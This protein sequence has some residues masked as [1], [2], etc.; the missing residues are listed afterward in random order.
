[1]ATL[2]TQAVIEQQDEEERKKKRG[3]YPVEPYTRRLALLYSRYSTSEQVK[4]SV[5]KGVEQSSTLISRATR[6]YDWTR[7]LLVI[8][9]ENKIAEDGRVKSVSGTIPIEKRAQLETIY[10][11]YIPSGKVGAIFVDDVSRL[12]R[13]ADLVDAAL[14]ARACKKHDVI[15]IT[16]GRVYNFRRE[17]DLDNFLDEAKAAALWLKTH[18]HDKM[19]RNRRIKVEEQGKLGNGVAPIGLM[20]HAVLDP[21]SSPLKRIYIEDT[22]IPS[23]HAPQVAWLHRRFRELA[24]SKA[25]LLAELAAMAQAGNPL[26]PVVDGIRPGTIYL[27]R[28]ERDGALLGWTIASRYG[29]ENILGNLA[30]KG[31]LVW[32]GRIVKENAWDAIV[33]P[34]DWQYAFDHVAPVDENNQ[35]VKRQAVKRFSQRD[36]TP[37]TALLAGCRHDGKPVIDGVGD[38]NVFVNVGKGMYIVEKRVGKY[39]ASAYETGISVSELD[40]IVERSILD[41]LERTQWFVDRIEEMPVRPHHTRTVKAPLLDAVQTVSQ[42]KVVQPSSVLAGIDGEIKQLDSDLNLFGKIMAVE[43]RGKAYEKLARLRQRKANIEQEQAR[44]AA[45]QEELEQGKA[46]IKAASQQYRSWDLER[47]RRF[48]RVITDS[49]LLEELADGWLRL[50]VTWS[51]LV[52]TGIEH[53]YIWRTSGHEWS[54]QETELLRERYPQASRHSLLETFPTRSFTAITRKAI[55]SG[56]RRIV[57]SEPATM[58]ADMSLSDKLIIDKYSVKPGVRVQ[59]VSDHL[60]DSANHLQ[61]QKLEPITRR[62]VLPL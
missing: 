29:L 26:F 23:P 51:E 15:I 44:E 41:R 39:G 38:A 53:C 21:E 13:D 18:L 61:E 11:E 7:D 55:A 32:N 45:H 31:T 60:P 12:T 27:T 37:N 35:P 19:L 10:K 58:P 46:D 6:D 49:I 1:M 9:L 20:R 48:F 47:K 3:E 17:G 57:D 42:E 8:F 2:R 59:W 28:V 54:E 56:I 14:L 16:T 40:G 62:V 52:G 22:L 30:Y 43:D 36:K 34:I 25:A 33:D 4:Q 50:T 24:A 5:K